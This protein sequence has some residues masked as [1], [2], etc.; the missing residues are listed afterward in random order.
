MDDLQRTERPVDLLLIEDSPSDAR[1]TMEALRDARI[2]SNIHT[3]ADGLQALEYLRREGVHKEAPTPDF[4]ILD[5]NLPK[6]N[7]LEVLQEIKE[8]IRLRSIPVIILSSSQAEQDI[9]KAYSYQASCY[10]TKPLDADQYFTAIRSLKELWFKVVSLP[11]R[12]STL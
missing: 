3:V 7:G 1:L 12:P 8:D 11:T 4:I 10:I 9:A 2:L 6:M 5:L